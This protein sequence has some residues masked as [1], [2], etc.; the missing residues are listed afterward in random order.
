MLISVVN[1]YD[2]IFPKA[3]LEV[4]FVGQD[5]NVTTRNVTLVEHTCTYKTVFIPRGTGKLEA[6]SS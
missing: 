4:A 6:R 5:K 1:V 3:T 2:K